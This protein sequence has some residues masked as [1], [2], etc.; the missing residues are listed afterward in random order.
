L[1]PNDER[2]LNVLNGRRSAE[3]VHLALE[4]V[5]NSDAIGKATEIA[6]QHVALAKEALHPL[7][8]N[9]AR[10]TLLELADFTVQRKL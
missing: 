8:A 9:T 4:A 2:I 10:Q 5:R 6:R 3:S 1:S 7:P